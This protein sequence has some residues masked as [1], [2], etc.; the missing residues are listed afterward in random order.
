LTFDDG[1]APWTVPI[2]D[3]LAEYDVQASFFVIG[4]LI[5]A[6]E[7][8]VARIFADGHEIG[9]HSWSHPRLADACDDET[10][11]N[12][13]SRTNAAITEIV[14]AP[15]TR[16]R[17][18]QYNTSDRVERIAA[19]LALVHTRGDVRPPDWLPGCTPQFITTFVLQQLKPSTVVGLHD[20]VPPH[21][22]G[23]AVTR[24]ATVDSVRQLLAAFVAR[25]IECVTAGELL[26]GESRHPADLS[27]SGQVPG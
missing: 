4:S 16:F 17:A 19:R 23:T 1:P 15:P 2:L 6:N 22:V 5:S 12:E 25:G 9:N 8:I 10:V 27:N 24:R 26:A 21:K 11:F 13:L 14:G 18:P 7:D 3:L 20:G